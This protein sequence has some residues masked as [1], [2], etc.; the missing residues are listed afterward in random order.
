MGCDSAGDTRSHSRHLSEVHL[1]HRGQTIVPIPQHGEDSGPHHGHL[2]IRGG[3]RPDHLSTRS[4]GP[5]TTIRPH[6]SDVAGLANI[7][8]GV[9]LKRTDHEY[10]WRHAT[11]PGHQISSPIRVQHQA[12]SCSWHDGTRRRSYSTSLGE[13]WQTSNTRRNHCTTGTPIIRHNLT[14]NWTT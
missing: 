4:T 7:S 8:A 5:H 6:P 13:P 2:G 12:D 3:R 14:R 9:P 10:L 1:H 11:S